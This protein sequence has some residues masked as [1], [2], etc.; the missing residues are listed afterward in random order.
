MSNWN[1]RVITVNILDFLMAFKEEFGELN[2]Y[3]II[4]AI[5]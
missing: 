2:I 4:F 1:Y 3:K 5:Q